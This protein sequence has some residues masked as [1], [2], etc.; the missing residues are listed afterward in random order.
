MTTTE[1]NATIKRMKFWRN[2]GTGI[3][4][5]CALGNILV[6]MVGHDPSWSWARGLFIALHT[7]LA[8]QCWTGTNGSI[9]RV[10]RL[11]TM[12]LLLGKHEREFEDD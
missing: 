3:N 9:E 11:H 4:V 8:Y 12:M 1:F 2:L 7:Y 10:I 6:I 5:F